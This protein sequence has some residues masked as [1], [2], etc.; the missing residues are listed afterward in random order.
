M[1]VASTT[2][3]WMLRVGGRPPPG[4]SS[5]TSQ[6]PVV[7]IT[8]RRTLAGDVVGGGGD[9]GHQRVELDLDAPGPGDDELALL[10]ELAVA[11]VDQGRRRARARGGRRG[12]TRSTAPC[13]GP[14]PR[15]RSC[16]GRPR[17]RGRRAGG[18]PSLTMMAPIAD[19]CW[20]DVGRSAHDDAHNKDAEERRFPRWPLER[21]SGGLPPVPRPAEGAAAPG[22]SFADSTRALVRRCS[23][24]LRRSGSHRSLLRLADCAARNLRA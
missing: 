19:N 8:P 21:R 6:R 3:T 7:P 2:T 24:R 11:A 9:V 15:P 17:R 4:R 23:V 13:A 14:G 22:G 12:W 1:V 20:T 5:G 18:G 10:G 16:G